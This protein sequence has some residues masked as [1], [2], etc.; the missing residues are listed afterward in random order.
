MPN[1]YRDNDD[2]Q[3]LFRHTDPGKLAAICEENFKFAGEFDYA[4]ANTDEAIQN[5][6]MVLD[7][8]GQLCGDFIAPR[9]EDVDRQGNILNEDGSVTRA[10]GIQESIEKLGQAEVMGFTL[11]H[12][13]GGLNFPNLVY[14]MAIEI[15]SRADAA[16]MNIFGLQ[17]IAETI[18]A[19]AS[20]EIK[21]KYLHDFSAGKVTGAM[22]LT[23]PDAGSDLQAIKLRAFQDED[24]N[25]FLHGVKR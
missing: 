19:F 8:L 2:I 4:P 5:Y 20:E 6:D 3:F 14:T 22:V 9:A 21:Q 23:E 24:G 12:R 17:G 1:F 18:N 25:W 11:P 16:L 10:K 13:F 7:S 15:L